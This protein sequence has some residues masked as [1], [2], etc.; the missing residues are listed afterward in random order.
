MR[1]SV[2]VAIESFISSDVCLKKGQVERFGESRNL[3]GIGSGD[4]I[5]DFV[6]GDNLQRREIMTSL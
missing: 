6:Q 3:V 5:L 1:G 2:K 4:E